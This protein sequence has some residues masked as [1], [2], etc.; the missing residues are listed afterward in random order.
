MKNRQLDRPFLVG[1]NVYLRPFDLDDL[2]GDYIQ[3]INDQDMN[4]FLETTKT[5]I[6]K[7]QLHNY[8][9]NVL[10][11]DSY[12]FFA[13]VN[14]ITNKHIGNVKIGPINWV[15]RRSQYGRLLSKDEWG[16]GY[17]SEILLLIMKY[18]FEVLNL[19]K[20]HDSALSSNHASIQSVQ[21][22]GMEIEGELN[23]Y[24]Y[25]NGKYESITLYGIT[26]KLYFQKKRKG[27]LL[28][29]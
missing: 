7:D 8:V 1:K 13:V 6:T 26:K 25:H 17:G 2:N 14:K 19:N 4:K 20:L 21:K 29:I 5:P 22:A 12:V 28:Q 10:N 11:D 24:S 23:D 16:K 15:D 3:W 9:S 18:V 27:L